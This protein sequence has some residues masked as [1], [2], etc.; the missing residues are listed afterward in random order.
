ML[1]DRRHRNKVQVAWKV[2]VALII[3]SM[4]LLYSPIFG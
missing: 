4:V 1:F 2:L 3:A